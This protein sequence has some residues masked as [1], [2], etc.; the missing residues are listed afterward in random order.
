M[1]LGESQSIAPGTLAANLTV[2]GNTTPIIKWQSSLTADFNI[3]TDIANTTTTLTGTSIGV[4]SLSTYYRAITTLDGANTGSNA[5]KITITTPTIAPNLGPAASF[6]LF[7]SNGIVTGDGLTP[8]TGNVGTNS[9]A[10]VGFATLSDPLFHTQDA[11]TAACAN[12]LP[13]LFSTLK[14]IPKTFDHAAAFADG[15]VLAPGVYQTPIASTMGGTITLDGGGDT[16]AV[17]IFKIPGALALTAATNI[18]LINGTSASNVFW[19]MDGAFAAGANS[20]LAGTFICQSGIV[21]IG[22]GCSVNGHVFTLAGAITV[23]NT[24]LNLTNAMLLSAGQTIAVNEIPADL[25]IT[26]NTSPI[27]KWQSSLTADFNNPIDIPHYSA[28]LCGSCIGVLNISTYFR[29]VTLIDGAVTSSNIVKITTSNATIVPNLGPAETFLLFTSAGAIANA[30]TSTFTGNIGTNA[31]IISG[32]SNMS[33]PK[34]HTQDNLTASC[35]NYIF[36]LFSNVKAIPTT[37]LTHPPAFGGGETVTAGVYQIAIAS[38]MAGVLTL[39]AE[40]NPNAVF[41]F[42]INGALALAA[43][44]EIKL[45]NGASASNVFWNINGAFS[46]GAN[47]ILKGT[48]ICEKGIISLGANCTLDGHAYTNFGAVT[49]SN[50]SLTAVPNTNSIIVSANQNIAVGTIPANLTLIGNT[51]SVLKWEKSSDALFT[52]PISITNTTTTLTGSE[53]GEVTTSTYFRAVVAS[54]ITTIYSTT[55]VIKIIQNTIP[56][57]I[58]A[59]QN[60]LV[61]DFPKN[62]TISENNGPV[63]KWQKSTTL[64]FTNPIDISSNYALLQGFEIGIPTETTYIRAIVQNCISTVSYTNVLTISIG[65][66][67]A[68][69]TTIEPINGAPGKTNVVNVLTNATLNGSALTIDLI[70]LTTVTPNDNLILN[71]DGSLDVVPN[72]PAGTYTLTYQICEKLNATNCD[73]AEVIVEIFT[74]LPDFTP[75]IDIDGLVFISDESTKDFVINISEIQEGLSDGPIVIKISKQS[76]FSITY[77][78]TSSTSTAFGGVV[79]NNN[80]WVKTEDSLFITMTLKSS[81]IIGVNTFSAIGFT[82]KR[83]PNIPTQTSQPITVTIVNRSG[84]DSQNYNN[85][86]NTVVKAQ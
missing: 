48:F 29:A 85:T 83:K 24:K 70:N 78:A 74:K 62:I 14:A 60:I 57:I 33:D 61:G 27:I 79:V 63:S 31:G 84:L 8:F 51:S 81:V 20:V 49:L 69:K 18:K 15:E 16:N 39:D 80:D 50:S 10:I 64:N 76:A 40:N 21:G 2:T 25:I 3:P 36:E 86:Y 1:I 38:T 12:Y 37:N 6:V 17:F 13:E 52:N 53:I 77:G 7:T 5:A 55:V 42:K 44:A 22:A 73:Q 9:G 32:F 45:S 47:A 68:N 66:I 72:T 35:A 19:I 23:T 28:K 54:G 4:L 75:T 56:G 67:F 65:T 41:V 43:G 34:L 26:G 58:S 82:I 30:G 11:L 59:N 46:A 71:A